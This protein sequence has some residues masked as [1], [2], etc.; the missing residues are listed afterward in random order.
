MIAPMPELR[1]PVPMTAAI[2]G[3]GGPFFSSCSCVIGVRGDHPQ[4]ELTRTGENPGRSPARPRGEDLSGKSPVRMS[5]GRSYTGSSILGSTDQ[6][7]RWAFAN[8]GGS[9]GEL[10]TKTAAPISQG[11]ASILGSLAAQGGLDFFTPRACR[12]GRSRWPNKRRG[13]S[14]TLW[15]S[16]AEPGTPRDHNPATIVSR[17]RM[18]VCVLSWTISQ[19]HGSNGVGGAVRRL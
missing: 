1:P 19:G 7:K 6:A 11:S 3:T 8:S 15:A 17:S 16:A 14:R 2:F 12:L 10:R 4:R 13:R 9:P 18:R 5:F